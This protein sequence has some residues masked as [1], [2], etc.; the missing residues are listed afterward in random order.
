MSVPF[1][2][3]PASA[4]TRSVSKIV[5]PSKTRTI[6]SAFFPFSR[7]VKISFALIRALMVYVP[8]F[9]VRAL[10]RSTASALN[11][12]DDRMSRSCFR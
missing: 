3:T 2:S 8:G 10:R 1:L 9:K 4:S 5:A 7:Y 6:S 12:Q 11:A